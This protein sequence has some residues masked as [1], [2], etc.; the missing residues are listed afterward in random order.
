MQCRLRRVA[1]TQRSH[2][3]PVTAALTPGR[4]PAHRGSAR[5]RCASYGPRGP[6][7][8]PRRRRRAHETFQVTTSR[9]LLG[10]GGEPSGNVYAA[11]SP[12]TSRREC[13]RPSWQVDGGGRY[14][15]NRPRI[16]DR[17]AACA[18]CAWGR[19]A[20]VTPTAAVRDAPAGP[21]GPVRHDDRAGHR[22]GRSNS[23]VDAGRRLGRGN[24]NSCVESN[25][26][27][28]RR[29][30][31]RPFRIVPPSRPGSPQSSCARV[32]VDRHRPPPGPS[33]G[34]A[35]RSTT[36]PTALR[37][38]GPGVLLALERASY[39]SMSRPRRTRAGIAIRSVTRHG[40]DCRE[41]C[42]FAYDAVRSFIRPASSPARH[43]CSSREPVGSR[44]RVR[45]PLGRL[46][47]SESRR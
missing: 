13:T 30:S 5:Q 21:L 16:L 34:E 27:P 42:T 18:S 28:V 45:V 10:S 33:V 6:R 17:P 11:T 9:Q 20:S 22:I 36:R 40:D 2:G 26:W 44:S 15:P 25:S 43:E 32:F 38:G 3:M 23:Y 37:D 31:R 1:A 7:A 47:T 39:L 35:E 41:P 24:N 19:R 8:A 14:H 12:A 29:P 4:R 46:T